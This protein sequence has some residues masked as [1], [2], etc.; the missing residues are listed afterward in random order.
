[1]VSQIFKD[2]AF[3]IKKIRFAN[4]NAV[5]TGSFPVISG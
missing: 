2:L 3:V 5:E 1:M 4:L